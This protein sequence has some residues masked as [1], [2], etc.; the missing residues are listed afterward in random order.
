MAEYRRGTGPN[1]L[2]Q[3][4]ASRLNRMTPDQAGYQDN[5]V[6]VQWARGNQPEEPDEDDGGL[7]ENMQVLLSQH[8]TG[9][10]PP[11]MAKQRAT[12]VPRYVVRHLPTLYAA[13]RLPDA[14]PTLRGMFNA[15]VRY[16]ENEARY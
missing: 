4:A 8:D 9:Y 7:S 14:P 5:T 12:R 15:V 6:P 13:S 16:M 3:G 1:A 10:R 2:P 11:L